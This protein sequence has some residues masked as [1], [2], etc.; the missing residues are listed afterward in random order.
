M[1]QDYSD[2]QAVVDGDTEA[3]ERLIGRYK[4]SVYKFVYRFVLNA[5]DASEITEDVFVKV[6]FKAHKYKQRA[7]VKTWIFT[8]ATNACKDRLRRNK[9]HKDVVS[10]YETVDDPSGPVEIANILPSEDSAVQDQLEENEKMQALL[11]IIEQLPSKYRIPFVSCNI[12]KKSYL[13]CAQQ[14]NTTVK[15]VEMRIYRAKKILLKSFPSQFG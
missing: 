12:D 15:V 1:D 9:K 4:S 13:E 6:Y 2:L 8:I 3:L 7:S 10:I 5:S 11:Q 14:L